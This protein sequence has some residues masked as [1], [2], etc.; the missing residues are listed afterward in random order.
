MKEYIKI[1]QLCYKKGKGEGRDIDKG[2]VCEKKVEKKT[3][4]K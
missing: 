1:V 2:N 3:D 4:K